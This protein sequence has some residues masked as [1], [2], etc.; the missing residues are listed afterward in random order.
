MNINNTT[1]DRSTRKL[2]AGVAVLLSSALLLVATQAIGEF[3]RRTDTGWS[4]KRPADTSSVIKGD[5]ERVRTLIESS[6]AARKILE[7]G[8]PEA[9]ALRETAR[10]HFEA[11]VAVHA[12]GNLESAAEHLSR[13]KILLFQAARTADH[14]AAVANKKESD[15]TNRRDSIEALLMAHERITTEQKK[16]D[17]HQALVE[18]LSPKLEQAADL[19]DA[20]RFVDARTV[21]DTAYLS[22][23][24]SIENLRGGTTLTRS[25]DFGSPREEYLYELDRNQALTMLVD[26]LLADEERN[27]PRTADRIDGYLSE[28]IRLAGEA[29][30]LADRERFKEAIET[31]DRSTRSIIKA[32]RTAG[33]YVPG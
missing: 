6:S 9:L 30:K 4:M 5:I 10:E 22:V 14:G 19:A 26:V 33:V 31:L 20:D 28:A 27:N 25:L 1:R 17:L 12:N 24:A 15:Y 7:S 16:R 21:L 11:A 2:R 13:A 18:Q 3:S 29:E 8:S 32:I 23:K